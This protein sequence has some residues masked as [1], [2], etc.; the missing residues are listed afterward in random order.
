MFSEI[1]P[2]RRA[3]APTSHALIGMTA[4][5]R[6]STAPAREGRHAAAASDAVAGG[7][8]RHRRP[9]GARAEARQVSVQGTA[10]GRA[11]ED[12]YQV[13]ALPSLE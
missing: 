13:G 10:I 4:P 2:P 9:F 6:R 7:H 3:A 1:Y 12:R 8:T 5:G 11:I